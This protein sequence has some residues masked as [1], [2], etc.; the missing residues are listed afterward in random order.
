MQLNKNQATQNNTKYHAAW[1]NVVL[2]HAMH[3]RHARVSVIKPGKKVLCSWRLFEIK[4][5]AVGVTF[6]IAS[7]ILK[8]YTP[9]RRREL[10][11]V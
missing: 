10:F 9:K 6:H 4:L 8:D 1:K 3:L 5:S 7:K 11:Q 2:L